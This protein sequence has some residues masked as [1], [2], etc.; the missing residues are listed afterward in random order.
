MTSPVW[1][2]V[3]VILSAATLAAIPH[4]GS[5]LGGPMAIRPTSSHGGL[6]DTLVVVNELTQGEGTWHAEALTP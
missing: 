2:T 5:T 4:P 1:T 3:L 6:P